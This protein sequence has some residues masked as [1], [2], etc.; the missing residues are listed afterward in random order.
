MSKILKLSPL[1]LLGALLAGCTSTITNLTPT[2]QAR[3]TT[4]FYPIEL[5]W[6]TR[7]QAVRPGSLTPY[8]MVDMESYKMRPTLGL[9]NR[10]ETVIPVPPGKKT[11]PYH[12]RVDYESNAFGKPKK[13][14]ALSQGYTLEIIEK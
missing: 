7:D 11:V 1:L 12:F 6:D 3:N 14:S 8:V 2:K 4:G 5:V 9:S 13:G 10:F